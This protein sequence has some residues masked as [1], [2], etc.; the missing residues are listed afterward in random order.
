MNRELLGLY[1]VHKVNPAGSCL[2]L[3]AQLPIDPNVCEGGDMGAPITITN[4]NSEVSRV[5]TD[6]ARAVSHKINETKTRTT[7]IGA[8]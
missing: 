3:L 4:P 2:P 5:F 1:K 6:L 7:E 8:F